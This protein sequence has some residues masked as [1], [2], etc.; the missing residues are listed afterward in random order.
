[1]VV[2]SLPPAVIPDA[3]IRIAA[4]YVALFAPQLAAPAAGKEAQ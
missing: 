1:M 4:G 3:P 2:L